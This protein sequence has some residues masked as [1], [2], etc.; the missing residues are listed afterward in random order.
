[1][2]AEWWVQEQHSHDDIGFHYDKDEAYASNISLHLPTSPYIS[3]YLP[4]SPYIFVHLPM[5]P[6]ISYLP[7]GDDLVLVL[8]AL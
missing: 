6:Y 7:R 2:G 4:I 8:R 3:L 5:S 1:M